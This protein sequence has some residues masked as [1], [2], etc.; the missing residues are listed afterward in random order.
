M[1]LVA[2][3][4]DRDDVVDLVTEL[5]KLAL[6]EDVVPVKALGPTVAPVAV[7][8]VGPIRGRSTEPLGAA[9]G[10]ALPWLFKSA[11][12]TFARVSSTFRT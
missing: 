8:A 3:P 1:A 10:P 4:A 6:R 9:H 11:M 2:V 5:R 7:L 12:P